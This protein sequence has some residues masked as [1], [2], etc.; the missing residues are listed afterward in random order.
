VIADLEG[1][2]MDLA[3]TGFD[4]DEL[5]NL[6]S[7]LQAGLVVVDNSWVPDTR[8]RRFMPGSNYAIIA[9]GRL[10]A[11]TPIGTVDGIAR[12]IKGTFGEEPQEAIDGFCQWL[13]DQGA[14]IG[15]APEPGD[16]DPNGSEDVGGEGG[17]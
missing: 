6:L 4:A 8:D 15:R 11:K 1:A 7:G 3:L 10:A 17:D 14:F 12:W 13:K 16:A 2:G 5:D 9:F